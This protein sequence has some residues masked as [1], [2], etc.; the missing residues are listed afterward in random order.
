MGIAGVQD[1]N[2]DKDKELITVKGTMDAKALAESLQERLKRKVEVVSPKKE[3]E[4]GGEKDSGGAK[5]GGGN[6]GGKKKKGGGGGG[7]GNAGHG[8]GGEGSGNF[9]EDGVEGGGKMEQSR[10]EFMV[11][12]YG[13]GYGYGHYYGPVYMEQVHAPQMFSDENPNAC[14]IM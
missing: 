13:Y 12:G 14:S 4:G 9:E 3:K 7:G 1:M 2:I 10:M 8:G 6:S 5:E 11:P